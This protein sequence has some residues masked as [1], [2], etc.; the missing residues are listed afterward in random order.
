M[1]SI[2]L[3]PR[4]SGRTRRFPKHKQSARHFGKFFRI[5]RLNFMVAAKS[6]PKTHNGYG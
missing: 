5:Q 3:G 6:E 1:F 2:S 4:K